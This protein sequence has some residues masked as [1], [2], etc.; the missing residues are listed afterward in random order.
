MIRLTPPTRRGVVSAGWRASRAYRDGWHEGL[1]FHDQLDAPLLA[2]AP[3]VV[4]QVA[5]S[6][7]YAGKY[8]VV[9]HGSGVKTRYLHAQQV[10][11][12]KGDRVRRG[13]QVGTV[14]AT[15]T[16]SGRPHVH[17]DTRMTGAALAE[18]AR[19]HGEPRGGFGRAFSSGTAVPSEPLMDGATYDEGV[20]ENSAQWG[21]SPRR[22]G[23]SALGLAAVAV[24]GVLLYRHLA[25][26]Y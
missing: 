13:Q 17:F 11:V 3:G 12:R 23:P 16:A 10:F 26:G 20:L 5:D 25:H 21:V 8:L 22:A 9:D 19:T 2:S 14:G 7:G 6:A 4:S 15:G 18:Y 24:A 1:D